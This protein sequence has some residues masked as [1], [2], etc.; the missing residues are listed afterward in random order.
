MFE[1]KCSRIVDPVTYESL[2]EDVAL[3]LC[4]LEKEFPPSF[5]DL[6][7]HLLV[8]LVEEL[9]ICGPLH[10]RWMYPMEHYMKSLKGFVR[11]KTR[12]EGG[13]AEGYALEEAL[14]LC[15]EYMQEFAS[16]R[17]RVWDSYEEPS[18][19]EEVPEGK[20]KPRR[21]SARLRG[22]AYNYVVNNATSAQA[23]RE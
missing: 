1:R 17:R 20:G 3:V 15:T 12:P 21:L 4:L 5:F 10:S 16:T 6:M 22:W 13:M 7:T 23:W 8:H 19:K 18:M 2:R 11:N 14:G 9:Q